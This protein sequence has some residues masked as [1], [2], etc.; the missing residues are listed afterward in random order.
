MLVNINLNTEAK[1]TVQAKVKVADEIGVGEIAV[2]QLNHNIS[3]NLLRPSQVRQKIPLCRNK[4][5]LPPYSILQD[6]RRVATPMLV[7]RNCLR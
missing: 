4:Q 6:I 3:H 1:V 7:T 5:A 2:F